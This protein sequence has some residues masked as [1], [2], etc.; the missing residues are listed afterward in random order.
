MNFFFLNFRVEFIDLIE[1]NR[2]I[3]EGLCDRSNAPSVSA[4]SR[5]MKGR[6]ED[7]V[8]SEKGKRRIFFFIFFKTHD[9]IQGVVSPLIGCRTAPCRHVTH[10]AAF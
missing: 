1:R 4:I 5:L 7:E 9:P 6:D 10:D 2:L 3:K 8:K